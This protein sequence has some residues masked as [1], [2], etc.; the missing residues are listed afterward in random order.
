MTKQILT[1]LVLATLTATLALANNTGSGKDKTGS[2]AGGASASSG[3]TG[4]MG[5]GDM[6]KSGS[7][8][9]GGM[10]KGQMMGQFDR[11][12]IQSWPTE[13]RTAAENMIAKYGQPQEFTSSKLMW[14]D[15]GQFK[16]VS[17]EKEGVDHQF[18][19]AHKGVLKQVISY[20]VP[21][22]KM[23][24][25]A[26]F[27]G[28]LIVDRTKGE[29]ASRSDREEAN[30]IALNLADEII[31]GKTDPTK[32]RDTLARAVSQ[33]PASGSKTAGSSSSKQGDGDLASYAQGL[34]F[35]VARSG[36][37]DPDR[38]SSAMGQ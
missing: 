3:S 37:A 2:T 26:Q 7:M 4:S 13:S 31:K 1:A 18:P 33:L 16:H 8:G 19:K 17:V 20:K 22:D 11:S 34:K 24:E 23:D 30:F 14:H 25:L 38:A 27:N 32:A 36:T 15:V 10:N 12:M 28:S 35:Q 21:A 6:N 5:N 29:L 9:N